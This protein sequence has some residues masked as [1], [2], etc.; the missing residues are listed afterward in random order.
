MAA[1]LHG[2]RR[3]SL[4]AAASGGLALAWRCCR[5]RKRLARKGS[6]AE[7][8]GSDD[9]HIPPF[10]RW[11]Y[12][13]FSREAAVQIAYREWRA[14]GQPVVVPNTD[15]RSTM[16]APRACGSGS[17]NIG[18]SACRLGELADQGFTGMHDQNGRVF[19]AGRGRQ[20]RLVGGLYRLCDAHGRGGAPLPVFADPFR[21]HQRRPAARD[22]RSNLVIVAER[23]ESY[24]PQRGDLICYVARPPADPL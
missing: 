3:F 16:S 14:F 5:L 10:A 17:A 1:F 13:R 2:V 19:P 7:R 6:R 8:P 11:P 24:A 12:Q 23:P 22:R 18:G 21:L 4:I 9:I 20:F 15:C